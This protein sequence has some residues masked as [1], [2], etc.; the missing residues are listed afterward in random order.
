MDASFTQSVREMKLGE[1]KVFAFPTP[2]K[3]ESA[4]QLAYR[5]G[6]M[7]G[8]HVRCKR[9]YDKNELLV[10]IEKERK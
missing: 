1:S 6:Q 2:Q 4:A 3:V 8:Y 7:N 9:Y 10:I 5:Y